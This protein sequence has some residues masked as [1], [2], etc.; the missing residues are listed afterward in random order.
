MEGLGYM[1]ELSVNNK[2]RYERHIALPE[3]G[4]AGQRALS[5]KH[6]LVVGA[7]GLGAPILYYL[8]A[9][10]V[11]HIT[12]VDYDRVCLSNLQRQILYTEDDLGKLKVVVAKSRL[13]RLNSTVIIRAINKKITS[14]NAYEIAKGHDMIIDG[15]DNLATRYVIDDIAKQ[16]AIPFLY[17]AVSGFKGQCSLFH[18]NGVKG[19]YRELFPEYDIEYDSCPVGLISSIPGLI[20]SIMATEALKVLLGIPSS[21]AGYLLIIDTLTFTS[22]RVKL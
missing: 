3:I 22:M 16:L 4:E 11:G 7:G 6:I 5:S 21:L 9:G 13:L 18:Y 12:I 19:G 1:D 2:E 10:G 20:G 17:G 15:T 14:D 8:V